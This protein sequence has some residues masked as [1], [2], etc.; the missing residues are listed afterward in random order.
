MLDLGFSAS[1]AEA[2]QPYDMMTR[3]WR[4]FCGAIELSS[5]QRETLCLLFIIDFLNIRNSILKPD[6]KSRI[7]TSLRE[8]SHTSHSHS[9]RHR[10]ELMTGTCVQLTYLLLSVPRK[11]PS[12]PTNAF[13]SCF[14]MVLGINNPLPSSMK[15]I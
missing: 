6:L 7:V 15:S 11:G 13:K 3:V 4:D 5:Q 14:K 10:L 9:V 2:G 12:S 8:P 1:L